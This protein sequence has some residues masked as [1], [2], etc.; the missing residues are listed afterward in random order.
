M[1]T[2]EWSIFDRLD[3]LEDITLKLM[4]KAD[5]AEP[6]L[7]GTSTV[8]RD[9]SILASY[10]FAL[11]VGHQILK[12]SNPRATKDKCIQLLKEAGLSEQIVNKLDGWLVK[13]CEAQEKKRRS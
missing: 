2:P 13:A 10:A 1:G 4:E 9:A 7:K 11:G 6:T 5:T 12:V 8:A 3:E